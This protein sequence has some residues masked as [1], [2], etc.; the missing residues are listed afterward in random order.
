MNTEVTAANNADHIQVSVNDSI[1][2]IQINRPEK[3]NAINQAMYETMRAALI[4]ADVRDDVRVIVLYGVED[5]FTAGNDLADFNSR[6]PSGLSKAGEFLL[7][8]HDLKKPLVAAVSGLAVGIGTTLLLHCDLVYAA[9][10]TRFRLPFVNLGLC[11]EAGSSLLLSAMA[12]HRSASE[13]LLLG[14]FFDSETAI[15]NGLVNQTKPANE[16]LEFAFE[17]AQQLA[18]QPPKALLETKRLLK[19]GCYDEIKQRILDESEVFGQL[20]QSDESKLARQ[21]AAGGPRRAS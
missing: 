1:M 17:Q 18:K 20:L 5:C 2:S 14:G 6:E 13:L 11:P 12:G 7:V 21:G 3:K 15:K 16:L 4:D 19:S 8:L 9:V 10:E